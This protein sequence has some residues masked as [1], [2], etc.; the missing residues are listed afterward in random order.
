MTR[1][2]LPS[3]PR[4][5]EPNKTWTERKEL[6]RKQIWDGDELELSP[7]SRYFFDVQYD[8]DT[9]DYFL[10]ENQE[11]E[12][13]N[14]AY[15]KQLAAYNREQTEYKADVASYPDRLAQWEAGER[16][17]KMEQFLRLKA[18]LGQ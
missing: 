17:R 9:S 8:G 15:A 6:N 12:R 16:G 10:V 14:D 7:T 4:L 11:V 3:A 18:E 2:Q 1:P 13:P 5:R